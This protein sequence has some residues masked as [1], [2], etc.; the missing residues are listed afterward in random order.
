MNCQDVS[1]LVDTGR[2]DVLAEEDSRE[3]GSHA[4][5]CR[6]CAPL[7]AAHAGLALLSVPP[8]PA[9][10]E[11]RC[12]TSW[13][14]S[15]RV[16]S[17]YGRR[18]VWV[19]SVIALAAAA[20]IFAIWSPVQR[21]QQA[22]FTAPPVPAPEVMAYGRE[23]E[24]RTPAQEPVGPSVWP[25]AT[26]A[27]PDV[28]VAQAS[29]VA[30]I[31]I[32]KDD[33]PLL[34][35]P[36]SNGPEF[37]RV[38]F[39]KLLER[40]PEIV[41]GPVV[42]GLY[43]AALL[44]R[45]DGSVIRSELRHTTQEAFRDVDAE[46]EQTLPSDGLGSVMTSRPKIRPLPDGRMLRADVL[47]R[48]AFVP[49]LY[50]MSRSTMRVQ[51]IIGNRYVELLRPGSDPEKN[52]VLIFLSNAGEILR[53]VVEKVGAGAA[54]GGTPDA[55]AI[56]QRFAS[57]VEIEADQIGLMGNTVIQKGALRTVVDASGTSRL[58]DH[59]EI[60]LVRFAWQRNPNESGPSLGQSGAATR[61]PSVNPAHA[62]IVVQKVLPDAFTHR[63]AGA[64]TPTIVLTAR[65]AV[66]Q[67]GW[68][69]YKNLESMSK[70]LQD[71]LVPGIETSSFSSVTVTDQDGVSANVSLAWEAPM[72]GEL[73]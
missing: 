33:L 51:E 50:D 31:E 54:S 45:E 48:A 52:R 22:A 36:V 34:P 32:G 73:R 15:G 9:D 14:S 27:A 42:D 11:L 20:G 60:L 44:M 18:L 43:A 21:E 67:A 16:S 5:T 2:Y 30:A 25:I 29:A 47:L 1:R 72:E 68:V 6:H 65:G 35:R 24:S 70:T 62:L 40:H 17:L 12:R 23:S 4:A 28:P 49:T 10:V 61:G 71:Q 53:E 26:A 64:G 58:E 69:H 39:E 41:E 7:W 56:A 38:A 8:M 63:D 59:R 19:G 55:V 46:L 57:L 3:A 37:A 66:K 13:A